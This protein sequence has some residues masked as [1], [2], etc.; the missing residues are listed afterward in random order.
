MQPRVQGKKAM[1]GTPKNTLFSWVDD[2]ANFLGKISDAIYSYAELGM[3]ELYTSRTLQDAFR[4]HGFT[5]EEKISGIPTA[6]LATYGTGKPTVAFLEEFDALPNTS[7]KPGVPRHD[8]IVD[9][10]PGHGEGHNTNAAVLLGSALALKAV[11]EKHHLPGRIKAFGVPAE[12]QLVAR[13]FFVRDGY[14]QDVDFALDGHIY[15]RFG[16]SYGVKSYGLIS[17]EFTFA[18]K[19]AHAGVSPW[20]GVSAL[21][22]VQLMNIGYEFLR[23]HLPPSIRVHHVTSYG[24]DQPNVVPA[25]ASTWYFFRE[26]TADAIRLLYEKARQVAAGAALM[27]GTTVEDRILSAVWPV[28]ANKLLAEIAWQNIRAIG[29]PKWSRK[30]QQLA[31]AVQREIGLDPVGLPTVI[32]PL[33]AATPSGGSSDIG[34]VSWVVPYARIEFPAQPVG[35]PFHHWSAGVCAATSI[36]HKGIAVGVKAIVATALDVMT[37]PRLL[38]RVKQSFRRELAKTQYT[39]L[40][41]ADASPPIH[42]NREV[43]EKYRAAMERYYYDPSSPTPYAEMF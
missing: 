25:R 14:L 11:M 19:T 26:Q 17:A 32:E 21:D 13:P 43:M 18:G 36:A 6:F 41:P 5:V 2:Q 3:Q 34:D 38:T 20:L 16:T 4:N 27:T 23:E 22:A 9:G 1:T 42:L 24:G 8:P 28:R 33:K 37:Q 15:S 29:M 12:E 35:I 40:L 39:P 30:E 31:K 10:A 7:Q